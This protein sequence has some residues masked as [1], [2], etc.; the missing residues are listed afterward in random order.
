MSRT[1]ASSPLVAVRG[2]TWEDD[3][4]YTDADGLPI[5][6]TGYEARM[7]VRTLDGREGT[8]G[9][10]TL[11]MLLETTGANPRLTWDTAAEGRLRLRV[12]AA[13]TVDLN[14]NNERKVKL[15]YGVEVFIPEGASPE[16][17][18]PLVEGTLTVRSESVR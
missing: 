1:P 15:W 7:Q 12:E 9:V 13:D 14:P 18:V 11:V 3:F 8:S 6:L 16:Y 10:E 5:D 17:V 2:S 4:Q